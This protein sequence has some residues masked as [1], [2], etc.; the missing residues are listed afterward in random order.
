V[1]Q[2]RDALGD[3]AYNEAFRHG[4]ELTYDDAIAYA[5]GERR[6]PTV[7]PQRDDSSPLTRRERQIADLVAQG[8]SNKDTASTL[9]ISQRTAESHVEH[10]LT[11]LGFTNR[12]EV[13]AWTAEQRSDTS[14]AGHGGS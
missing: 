7:P 6:E 9:V 10:I 5:L 12:A 13:A 2:A 1:R 8:L 14:T 11:K 3:A 4:Q